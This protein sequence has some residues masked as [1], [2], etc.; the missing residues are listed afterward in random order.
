MLLRREYFLGA[1][2]WGITSKNWSRAHAGFAKRGRVGFTVGMFFSLVSPFRA[3]PPAV[4]E[5][6]QIASRTVPLVVVRN[7]RARRYHL[8]VQPDGSVRVTIP[9]GGSWGEAQA[10]VERN[11]GWLERHIERVHAQPRLPEAWSVGTEIIFRGEWVRLEALDGG[12]IRFGTE[13]LAAPDAAADLRPGIE[14]YLRHLAAREL[15]LRVAELAA[16]HQLTVRR[17]TVRNQRSRWGS[18]S[19]HGALSLNWRLIQTPVAVR[20]YIILHELA[21]LRELNHSSR[22][23]QEVERLC[24][25]YEAAE[26]W[27]KVNRQL[28]R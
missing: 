5:S 22:F 23:W 2:G 18:C 14:R 3:R 13:S 17:V 11:R 1:A 12:R 20:D 8:R 25:D 4:A 6:L 16:L 7:P 9:R 24:P 27:L 10:F 28:L 21:H 26:N 19:R 15:P